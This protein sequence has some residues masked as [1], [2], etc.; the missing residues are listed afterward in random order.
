MCSS[1]SLLDGYGRNPSKL[2]A[3]L[4]DVDHPAA[5]I[6]YVAAVNVARLNP[7]ARYLDYYTGQLVYGSLAPCADVIDLPLGFGHEGREQ[8]RLNHVVYVG[9]VARLLPVAM[10]ARRLAAHSGLEKF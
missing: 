9:E 1:E 4:F 8:R 10:Y 6:V 5:Y 3:N 7:R 2:A